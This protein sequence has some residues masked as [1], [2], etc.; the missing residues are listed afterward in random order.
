MLEQRHILTGQVDVLPAVLAGFGEARPLVELVPGLEDHD[1]RRPAEGLAPGLL[2]ERPSLAGD[3]Q[4]LPPGDGR[5]V[6]AGADLAH[7][8][9]VGADGPAPGVDVLGLHLPRGLADDVGDHAPELAGELRLDVIDAA[10]VMSPGEAGRVEDDHR[11]AV[12]SAQSAGGIIEKKSRM[13]A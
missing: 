4:G 7:A 6:V 11:M 1:P 2:V 10:L 3:D 5:M 9:E 12:D 8:Q 13:L